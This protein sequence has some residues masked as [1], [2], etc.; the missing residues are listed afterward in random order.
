MKPT[1]PEEEMAGQTMP[2]KVETAAPEA[3]IENID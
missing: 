2:E 1:T 3:P